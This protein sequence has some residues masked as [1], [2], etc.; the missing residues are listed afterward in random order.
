[1]P[2]TTRICRRSVPWRNCR[3]ITNCPAAVRA[4]EFLKGTI[5][6][7]SPPAVTT[8]TEEE[9]R[10]IFQNGRAV[11]LRNW[12][13][14]WTLLQNGGDP[15]R[16]KV[17]VTTMVHAQ[18]HASAASLGGWGFG[19]SSFC[20]DPERAWQF[21][22]FLTRPPQLRLVQERQGRIPSRVSM[23]PETFAPAIAIARMRPAIPEYAQAS[24]ILQRWLSA[25]LTGTVSPKRAV[26][27]AARETWL[28]LKS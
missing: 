22:S 28:L 26:R 10:N 27:E 12:P 4:I 1:M 23:I 5:G 2:P 17:G 20:R 7:I 19:I 16:E 11:F 3:I 15:I 14:V 18:G 13:Y 6:T 8:Y 21:I 9:T 24:D 25:A